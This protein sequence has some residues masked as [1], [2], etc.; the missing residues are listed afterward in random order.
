MQTSLSSI[1]MCFKR[2][3]HNSRALAPVSPYQVAW[4]MCVFSNDYETLLA[5]C[6]LSDD[7]SYRNQGRS[8]STRRGT[9]R[10]RP[11]QRADLAPFNGCFFC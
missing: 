3:P 10:D 2:A 8:S 9:E 6:H 7:L 4:A 11:A 1:A 5:A